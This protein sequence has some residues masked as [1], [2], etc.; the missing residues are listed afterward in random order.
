MY[1]PPAEIAIYWY[2]QSIDAFQ[3]SYF[4]RLRVKMYFLADWSVGQV[5]ILTRKRLKYDGFYNSVPWEYKK[6]ASV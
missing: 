1:S 3:L 6:V 4:P 5:I 2:S